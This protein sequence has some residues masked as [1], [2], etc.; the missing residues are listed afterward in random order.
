MFVMKPCQITELDQP[1]STG[2][3]LTS[4]YKALTA[5]QTFVLVWGVLSRWGQNLLDSLWKNVAVLS[6]PRFVCSA[7][8]SLS[9]WNSS[10][11][12]D[13]TWEGS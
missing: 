11:H 5:P 10:M 9:V 7:D 2:H 13:M 6:I 8:D 3:A 1:S 4:P 12:A